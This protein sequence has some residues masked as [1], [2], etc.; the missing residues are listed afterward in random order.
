MRRTRTWARARRVTN[1]ST[2]GTRFEMLSACDA[3]A[4]AY[5]I[6]NHKAAQMHHVNCQSSLHMFKLHARHAQLAPRPCG[7]VTC[8]LKC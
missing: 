7:D 8:I 6:T 4:T 1:F 3:T 2:D 5:H